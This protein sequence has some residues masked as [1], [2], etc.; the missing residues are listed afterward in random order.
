MNLI[1]AV[2]KDYAIGKDNKLLFSLPSDM[3]YFKEKTLNK[4]VVMGEKTYLS[5][6][7]RPL[8]NRINIVLSD[9]KNFAPE[10]AIVVDNLDELFSQLKKYNDDDI[11]V[12]GGASVYNLLMEYCHLAY[13]TIVDKIVPADTY[14]IDP[15]KK[16]FALRET[17]QTFEENG[18]KFTFNIFEN[19]KSKEY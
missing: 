13:V 4:V 19:K 14:I 11:F 15:I 16:G 10:G 2:A 12:C 9:N 17:S 7:K 6:P 8:I 5:L 18:L 3:K 1:V